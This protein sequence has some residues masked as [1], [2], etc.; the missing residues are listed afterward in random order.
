MGGTRSAQKTPRRLASENSKQAII[1]KPS[2]EREAQA[3]QQSVSATRKKV[4][5]EQK[6]DLCLRSSRTESGGAA[7]ASAAQS[8][9]CTKQGWKKKRWRG[10][11]RKQTTSETSKEEAGKKKSYSEGVRACGSAGSANE[12]GQAGVEK[13]EKRSRVVGRET[14]K[15]DFVILSFFKNMWRVAGGVSAKVRAGGGGRK[16]AKLATARRQTSQLRGFCAR[17]QQ[18]AARH[19][20]RS[21]RRAH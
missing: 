9:F 19:Q 7:A 11:G 8:T 1:K 10:G 16:K 13:L 15:R 17:S 6:H 18:R 20:H 4:F 2:S 3:S 5:K 14:K 21:P 12:A